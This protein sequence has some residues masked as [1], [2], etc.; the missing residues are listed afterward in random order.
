MRDLDQRLVGDDAAARDVDAIVF[1]ATNFQADNR[2]PSAA[3][4]LVA[5]PNGMPA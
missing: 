4:M 1:V 2:Y 3:N 5:I